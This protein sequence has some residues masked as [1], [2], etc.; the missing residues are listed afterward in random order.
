MIDIKPWYLSR[1][2][3]ASIVT[4]LLAAASA[5][6]VPVDRI[7]QS[8]LVDLLLQMAAIGAGLVTLYGRLV[9]RSRIG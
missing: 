3:W 8:E 6:G 1:T 7:E 2:I 9:A 5:G 4:V